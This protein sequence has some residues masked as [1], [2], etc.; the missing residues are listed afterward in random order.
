MQ[1]MQKERRE[2]AHQREVRREERAVRRLAIHWGLIALVVLLTSLTGVFLVLWRMLEGFSAIDT[3]ILQLVHAE[4][5]PARRLFMLTFTYLGSVIGLTIQA[6]LLL[7][8]LAW[9]RPHGW[10]FEAA[11]VLMATAGGGLLNVF[12]K[13]TF[14][15]LRPDLF[16]GEFV[17][18]SFSFPSG[19]AMGSTCLYGV[20]LWVG[21]RHLDSWLGRALLAID[22]LLIVA[23][24]CLSRVYFAVHYP[25]D[26]VGGVLIGI[27]WVSFSI[28]SVAL[29]LRGQRLARIAEHDVQ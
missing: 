3:T 10:K 27:A 5:T 13:T 14:A 2:R 24:V 21:L 22:A 17:L 28:V 1:M 23:L 16:P 8:A 18:H 29:L 6:G 25:T 26:V 11:T 20:M 7:A 15:R 12:L 19:H 4:H 9:R